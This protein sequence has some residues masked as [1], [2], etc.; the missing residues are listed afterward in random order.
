VKA[1]PETVSAA[2]AG[3]VSQMK[4]GA[5]AV[6]IWNQKGENAYPIAAFTYVI[7]YKD[8]NNLGSTQQ[9]QALVDYLNWATTGG[10]RLASEMDYAPLAPAVQ[11]RVQE[12][13]AGLTFKGRTV[14]PGNAAAASAR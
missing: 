9:A 8:L 5:L 6:D 2:G 13:L 7:V 12:E 4:P 10:Q 3:A 14:K 1:S 11:K